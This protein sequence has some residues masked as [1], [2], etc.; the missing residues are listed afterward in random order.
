MSKFVQT[1]KDF[2]SQI[3]FCLLCRRCFY[4][5]LTSCYLNQRFE[6]S[7]SY[8]KSTVENS[9]GTRLS[10]P[11]IDTQLKST[12]PDKILTCPFLLNS[13][14]IA[15]TFISTAIHSF[16]NSCQSE[17]DLQKNIFNSKG[18]LPISYL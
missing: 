4:L 6:N 9:L 7:P 17:F 15:N 8:T 5:L 12:R 14:H 11:A 1:R 3:S 2:N 10:N 18:T 16:E 13:S